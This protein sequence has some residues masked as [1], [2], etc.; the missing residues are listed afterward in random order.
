L[1][2]D[3]ELPLNILPQP[4]DFSCGP[5]CLQAIL[6]YHGDSVE[7]DELMKDIRML[8]S[9]G[10]LAVF[11][12]CAALKRGFK[13]TIY[14]YNLQIFDPSWFTAADIDIPAKLAAQAAAKQDRRIIDATTGYLEFLR[15]GGKLRFVDLT[16]RLLR[17]ILRR[18]LPIL[19]GLS[20]T[21]LYHARREYGPRDEEDDIRGYPAG[22]FVLLNG[23]HR[24]GRTIL[25]TDPLIP[26][27]AAPTQRYPVNID[28]VICS[29]LLGV[30][31][32]DANLLVIHP[33]NSG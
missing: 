15:L 7:L 25:V 27:P 33:K 8:E 9:G 3:M 30:L 29:I 10:T 23:Y 22:H 14:T 20:A 2:M 16:T 21:Y 12:A 11:L 5:T 31:T 1:I 28:R 4:D 13:S 32:H 19:T 24:M 18:G 17:G 6:D 26:N